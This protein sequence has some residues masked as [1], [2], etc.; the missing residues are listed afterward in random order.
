MDTIISLL[1]KFSNV[2][3]NLGEHDA[4]ETDYIVNEIYQFMHSPKRNDMMTGERYYYG[5]HDIL[6]RKRTMIGEDGELEEVENLPNNRVVNNQYAKLVDQKTNY[7]LGNPISV[8]SENEAYAD[9]LSEMLGPS[10]HRTLKNIGE[11]ALNCGIGWLLVHYDDKGDLMLKRIRPYELI[12]GWKDAEHTILDFAIRIYPVIECEGV[13][14]SVGWRVEVFDDTGISYFEYDGTLKP[15]EPY[16]ED[17][18]VS[19]TDDSA[20]GFNWDRI[21][22]IAFKYNSKEIPLIKKCKVLQDGINVMMSDFE[23]NL[24]EDARNTVLVLTNFDGENLGEFRRNLATFGAVKIRNTGERPGGVSTL[25]I[26][27]NADNYNLVLALLKQA[28]IENAMGYD[29]KD[30]R[31]AGNP[32][33]MNIQSMYSDIDLDANGMEM[34]FQAAMEELLWFLNAHFAN[35]GK[36]DFTGEKAEITF[37]RDVLINES[38]LIA[39][40]RASEGMISKETS[41][42]KHPYVTDP[43]L[44]LERMRQEEQEALQQMMDYQ[45]LEQA[46]NT[47]TGG[48]INGDAE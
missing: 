21:P 1:D 33:Q 18:F 22:L 25:K 31:L 42:A 10:F 24:Q 12:P 13:S 19:V 37:N 14:E 29:A 2:F 3:A 9:Q 27:V 32:N 28:L 36:G 5:N 6:R 7:L 34:E 38:E 43:Q 15:C 16:H 41:V 11:D 8:Q 35:T 40:L 4:S 47:D 20:Q 17:Y 30:D 23:N 39:N 46:A 45:Q 48:D 44:E 26:D